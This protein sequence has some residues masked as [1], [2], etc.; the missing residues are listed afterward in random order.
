MGPH[1]FHMSLRVATGKGLE[2]IP[3]SDP[4]VAAGISIRDDI[5]IRAARNFQGPA[6]VVWEDG[7]GVG[8]PWCPRLP[9]PTAPLEH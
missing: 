5:G 3:T 8:L 1:R 9:P 7:V 6:S 2:D 4:D